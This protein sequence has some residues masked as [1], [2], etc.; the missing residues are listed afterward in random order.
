MSIDPCL[1]AS[2]SPCV[3]RTVGSVYNDSA[4]NTKDNRQAGDEYKSDTDN[5]KLL[6]RPEP[7]VVSDGPDDGLS[8]KIEGTPDDSDMATEGMGD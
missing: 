7:L 5:G 3:E 1:N 6:S 4:M 8:V 2:R